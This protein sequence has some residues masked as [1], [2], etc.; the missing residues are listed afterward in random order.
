MKKF[1]KPLMFA[2]LGV[3]ALSSCEDVPAPYDIPQAGDTDTEKPAV[4][5]SGQG[6][7]T[8][9]W[10]VAAANQACASLQ[11][12]N[13]SESHLSD[14]I[15]VKGIISAIS[16]IDTGSYGNATYYISDDGTTTDHL[17][18]YRGYY[19]NGNKFTAAEQIKI[20][21]E[22]VVVGKLQNWLGTYEFTQGSKL[23]SINGSS[24][25]ETPDT[26]SDEPKGDGTA[27]SPFN[28]AGVNA[29]IEA[30]DYK[31]KEVYITGI[32]CDN[33][34]ISTDYGNATFH[35]SEDG[36]ATGSE[37]F[38]VYRTM[39][40]NGEKIPATTSLKKGNTVVIRSTVTIYNGTYETE[41]SKGVLIS[42]NGEA[43]YDETEVPGEEGNSITFSSLYGNQ[44][45]PVL[46]GVT[47][48]LN[49][50][51]LTFSKGT[52]STKP[53]YYNTGTAVRLYGGNT[54][55]ISSDK[56][57]SKIDFNFATGIDSSN[58]PYYPTSS[59]AGITPDGY[60]FD[61]QTW[62][63]NANEVVLSYTAT[64]GHFRLIG[65]TITYAE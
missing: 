47:V 51:T 20:G 28:P 63:G 12:S 53:Q 40:F 55:T 34:N 31:G 10:N 3:F 11:Q 44:N 48:T 7:L 50:A 49:D 29:F 32:I 4:E 57:I 25:P 39:G 33:P 65:L 36:N 6:T 9:P 37:Q 52:G 5:P 2:L 14:E 62:T 61:T 54:L 1:W 8:D 30:G 17:E 18:V 43:A 26:P 15:Y 19:L 23:V 35:I 59:N 42:V 21:D 64:G 56:V 16:E 38:Y 46:D 45:Q 41:A 58:R 24:V 22:V 13:S 60:N 27:A